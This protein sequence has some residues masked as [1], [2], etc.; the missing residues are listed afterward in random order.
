[1]A[2]ALDEA[3]LPPEADKTLRTFFED[4]ATFLIN[5]QESAS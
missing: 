3:Q 5:R 4:V 2:A 1:M